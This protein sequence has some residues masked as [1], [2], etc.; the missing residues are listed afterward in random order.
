MV[1][2]CTPGMYPGRSCG[3]VSW[4]E[5]HRILASM[6]VC[7]HMRVYAC[8]YRSCMC[9]YIC[10]CMCECPGPLVSSSCDPS[11]NIS[12]SLLSHK[13]GSIPFP[14]TKGWPYGWGTFGGYPLVLPRLLVTY[15]SSP[16]SPLHSP[17]L[18]RNSTLGPAMAVASGNS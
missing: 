12:W 3:L 9:M 10:A 15:L 7:P 18:R 16:A 11:L 17:S 4:N 13:A 6:C 14:D 5:V 1:G 2:G 8:G